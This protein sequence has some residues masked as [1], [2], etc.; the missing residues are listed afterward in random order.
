MKVLAPRELDKRKREQEDFR[1]Q[2]AER[3][4]DLVREQELALNLA[5]DTD[6]KEREKLAKQFLSFTAEIGQR[7]SALESEVKDL[8]A[9]KQKALEPLDESLKEAKRKAEE[10]VQMQADLANQMV[11]IARERACVQEDAQ[12]SE[13]KRLDLQKQ[14]KELTSEQFATATIKRRTEDNAKKLEEEMA[15]FSGWKER[16]T[17]EMRS[18]SEDLA[19]QRAEVEAVTKINEEQRIRNEADRI[20]LNDRQMTLAA[21][22]EELKQKNG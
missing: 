12:T 16:I 5:R 2:K 9:R 4:N 10:V 19:R 1:V 6:R 17:T 18:H 7:K 21:A 14:E 20:R 13:R 8:E 3:L 11:D 15:F 22:F